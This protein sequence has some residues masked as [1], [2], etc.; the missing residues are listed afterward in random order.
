[1]HRHGF[2][3][4]HEEADG[5]LARSNFY[6]TKETKK[7]AFYKISKLDD[8]YVLL[9]LLYYFGA[10]SHCKQIIMESPVHDRAVID[11][12]GAVR[13]NNCRLL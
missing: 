11:I 3:T 12:F 1:M 13:S 9:L 7:R 2:K 10:Q 5:S 4:P 6:T 8:T